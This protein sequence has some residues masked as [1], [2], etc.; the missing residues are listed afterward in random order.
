MPPFGDMVP[1]QDVTVQPVVAFPVEPLGFCNPIIVVR[2]SQFVGVTIRQRISNSHD[3]NRRTFLKDCS[4]PLFSRQFRIF[5]E[6]VFRMKERQFFRKIRQFLGL[7]F[8]EQFLS[9]S[10]RIDQDSPDFPDNLF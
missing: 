4:F 2:R 6:K 7:Q 8:G 1:H 3:E 9:I 10:L 5:A